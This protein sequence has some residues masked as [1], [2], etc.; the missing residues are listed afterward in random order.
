MADCGSGDFCDKDRNARGGVVSL[1]K[2]KRSHKRGGE[3][4]MLYGGH[5]LLRRGMYI[6]TFVCVLDQ[7]FRGGKS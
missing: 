7:H 1:L 4:R 2:G 5:C 3:K 6:E